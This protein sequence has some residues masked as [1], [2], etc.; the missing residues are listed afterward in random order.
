MTDGKNNTLLWSANIINPVYLFSVCLSFSVLCVR[1]L[2][3]SGV[4][5]DAI[6][7]LMCST[8]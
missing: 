1:T 7:S 4:V 3:I 2:L 6:G 8:Y 5:V